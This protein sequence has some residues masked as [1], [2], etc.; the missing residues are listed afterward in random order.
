M[1]ASPWWNVEENLSWDCVPALL[2]GGEKIGHQ[3]AGGGF[4]NEMPETRKKMV[5]DYCGLQLLVVGF[6]DVI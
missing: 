2:Q 3:F 4:S 1:V 5:A 6:P